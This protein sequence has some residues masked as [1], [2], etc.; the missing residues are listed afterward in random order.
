M[1]TLHQFLLLILF[2]WTPFSTILGALSVWIIA[3]IIGIPIYQP[4]CLHHLLKV[5]AQPLLHLCKWYVEWRWHITINCVSTVKRGLS[6]I[7]PSIIVIA[8]GNNWW[9]AVL[10]PSCRTQLAFKHF[11][12]SLEHLLDLL[13]VELLERLLV[14]IATDIL[15]L[16]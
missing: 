8:P 10:L 3:F 6:A 14:A 11:K 2:R 7:L 12:L 13:R 15:V 9:G 16:L 1:K 4:L 5:L